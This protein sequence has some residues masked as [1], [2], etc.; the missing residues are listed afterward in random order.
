VEQMSFSR[1]RSRR[2][3]RPGASTGE[4]EAVELRDAIRVGT[5]ARAS[6][7]REQHHTAI[8]KAVDRLD[9]SDQRAHAAMIGLDG[10]PQSQAGRQRDLAY[11]WPPPGGPLHAL[12]PLYRYLAAP[13]HVCCRSPLPERAQWRESTPTIQDFQ[14][15]DDRADTRPRLRNRSANGH[16]AFHALNRCWQERLQPAVETKAVSRG[17]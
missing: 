9:A 16:R 4:K 12:P 3:V 6:Q 11:P 2:A 14:E 10:T 15:F 13:M 8:R 7:G 5:A 1:C 17:I